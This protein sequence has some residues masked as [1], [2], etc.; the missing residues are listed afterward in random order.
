MQFGSFLAICWFL[1]TPNWM[2]KRCRLVTEAQLEMLFTYLL[3]SLITRKNIINIRMKLSVRLKN[4]MNS[5]LLI[6]SNVVLPILMWKGES[7]MI[8]AI[9]KHQ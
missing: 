9:A 4:V 1:Q 3:I 5:I 8:Q 6:K 7:S 2:V